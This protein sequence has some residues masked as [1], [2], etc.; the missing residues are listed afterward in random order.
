MADYKVEKDWEFLCNPC[1]VD[2]LFLFRVFVSYFTASGMN[3]SDKDG[4]GGM[5][6]NDWIL[7]HT[8]QVNGN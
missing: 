6:D 4:G 2:S 8:L 1:V 5:F 3:L 7:C